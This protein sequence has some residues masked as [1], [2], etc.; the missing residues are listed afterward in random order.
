MRSSIS[1]LVLVLLTTILAACGSEGRTRGP[2]TRVV[3]L[4]VA[5]SFPQIG[6][7]REERVA[8]SLGFTTGNASSFEVGQYDFNLDVLPPG[9]SV[10]TRLKSFSVTLEPR[11]DY[12][13]VITDIGA[14]LEPLIVTQT[15]F[16]PASTSAE[17]SVVHAASAAPAVDIYL[18]APGAILSAANPIGTAAFTEHLAPLTLAAGDYQLSFTEVGNPLNV[19][20]TSPTI[21]LPAGRSHFFVIA[22]AGDDTDRVQAVLFREAAFALPDISVPATFRMINA[23]ADAQP[24]DIYLDSDFS[25]PFIGGA[26]YGAPTASASAALGDHRISVTPANNPG[27]IEIEANTTA[28]PAS[29]YSS[30]LAGPPGALVLNGFLEDRRRVRGEAHLRYFHGAAQFPTLQIALQT[31]SGL[32]LGFPLFIALGNSITEFA[33]A[34]GDYQLTLRPVGSSTDALGPLPITVADS[35]IYSIL[36]LNGPTADTASVVLF[37][38]FP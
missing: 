19:L 15:P 36:I 7:L 3:A 12:Y 20:Y 5:S 31:P 34:P 16:D 6:F 25:V 27:V 11:T 32:Y 33:L 10:P 35:G 9:Q 21:T 30:F 18:T 1:A 22:D 2:D 14:Q 38:D 17:A 28:F 24:R 26:A 23:A 29:F 13:F 8:A 4:H 37:D